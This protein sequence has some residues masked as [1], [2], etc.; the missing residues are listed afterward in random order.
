[1]N[2]LRGIIWGICAAIVISVATPAQAGYVYEGDLSFDNGLI[3]TGG[4][5]DSDTKLSWVVDNETTPGLWHYS[6]TLTVRKPSTSHMIIEVSDGDPGPAFTFANLFSPETDPAG[7]IQGSGEIKTYGPGP[8][9]PGIPGTMY[10]IKFDGTQ[11]ARIVTLEFDS[12]RVPVWGD[13]YAKGGSDSALF[14]E[15]FT[16]NDVDPTAPAASGSYQHHV[17]VPDTTTVNVPTP[18]AILLGGFGA[19]LLG[20]LRK[21]RTV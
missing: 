21:R 20:L 12:D 2:R 11:D 9:N 15:G 5:S 13:F 6:Y 18:G 8:S 17:L 14:N 10:G 16:A 3:A 4:W 1:M 19:G 7:W